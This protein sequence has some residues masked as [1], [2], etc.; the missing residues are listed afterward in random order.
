[1]S[2]VFAGNVSNYTDTLN[3]SI[4]APVLVAALSNEAAIVKIGMK[5]VLQKSLGETLNLQEGLNSIPITVRA[6]EGNERTYQVQLTRL[7]HPAGLSALAVNVGTLD[8]AFDPNRLAYKDTVEFKNTSVRVTATSIYPGASIKANNSTIV[9]GSIVGTPIPM[10]PGPNVISV[11][12]K[13]ATGESA[14][15]R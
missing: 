9:S 13:A 11:E 10:S 14:S 12:V 7:Y 4:V 2:P 5:T 8:S 1:M 3:N 6:E 15:T